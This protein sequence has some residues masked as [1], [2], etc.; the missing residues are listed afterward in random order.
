MERVLITEAEVMAKVAELAARISADY[1][2]TRPLVVGVLRG[3]VLFTADLLRALDVDAEVDFIAISSYGQSSRTS[4]VHRIIK[5]LDD[6]IEGRHVLLVEDIVDTGLTLR[7]LRDY[8]EQRNPASLRVVALL[9]KPDRRETEVAVE[10]I[11]F[12]IPDEFVVGYGLDYAQRYRN[13]RDICVL[14]RSVY[15]QT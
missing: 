1:R 7:Y 2:G 8:I 15:A 11:G 9:D 12:V 13:L 4:G 6:S 5:D 14:R 3:A 10:Y